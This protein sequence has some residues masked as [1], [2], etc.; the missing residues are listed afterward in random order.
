MNRKK[1]NKLKDYTE[2]YTEEAVLKK[3]GQV[4]IFLRSLYFVLVFFYLN[5]I[6][7]AFSK[8]FELRF[9]EDALLKLI[10]K[11]KSDQYNLRKITKK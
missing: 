2:K 11:I 7:E 6:V 10:F 5:G 8:S 3:D 9:T 1:L 4:C